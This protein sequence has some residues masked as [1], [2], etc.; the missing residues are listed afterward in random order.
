MILRHPTQAHFYQ[1]HEAMERYCHENR[2]S[3]YCNPFLKVI[4]IDAVNRPDLSRYRIQFIKIGITDSYTEWSHSALSDSCAPPAA[5]ECHLYRPAEKVHSSDPP[6]LHF[7]LA[8]EI[9]LR[10]GMGQ[11]FSYEA[12]EFQVFILQQA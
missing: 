2:A 8:E 1:Q 7:E 10:K 4:H 11:R 3:Q 12:I 9:L 6:A 5:S